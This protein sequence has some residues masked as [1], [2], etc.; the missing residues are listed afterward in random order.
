[1][2]TIMFIFVV[3]CNMQNITIYGTCKNTQGSAYENVCDV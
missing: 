1:M 2:N 3:K